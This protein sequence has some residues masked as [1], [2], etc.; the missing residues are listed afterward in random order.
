[1]MQ[2]AKMGMATLNHLGRTERAVQSKTRRRSSQSD[3]EL[4]TEEQILGSSRLRDL[5]RSATN[6]E[7]VQDRKHQS[8]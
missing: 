1:M 8:K 7:R 6:S 3:V 2:S 4:M 5:N